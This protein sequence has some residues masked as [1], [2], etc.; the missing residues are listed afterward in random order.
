MM[1]RNVAAASDRPLV[2]E[3]VAVCQRVFYHVCAD[4]RIKDRN[5]RE[6]LARSII[7]GYQR[8]VEDEGSLRRLFI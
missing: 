6:K 5:G 8:G 2:N 1:I 4:Q 3:G 7:D